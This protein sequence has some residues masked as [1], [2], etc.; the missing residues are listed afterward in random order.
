MQSRCRG[1][2]SGKDSWS[3]CASTWYSWIGSRPTIGPH[4]SWAGAW[5]GSCSWD[6][7]SLIDS[8]I[9]DAFVPSYRKRGDAVLGLFRFLPWLRTPLM[10]QF[11]GIPQKIL[12]KSTGDL[13]VALRISPREPFSIVLVQVSGP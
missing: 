7:L 13:C 5:T 10:Q 8:S 3:S 2:A 9:L 1:S 6:V 11:A 12:R 4:G